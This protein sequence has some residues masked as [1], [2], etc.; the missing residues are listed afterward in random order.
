[1]DH[2]KSEAGAFIRRLGGEEWLENPGHHLRGYARTRVAHGQADAM[3]GLN[4]GV[5]FHQV[6]VGDDRLDIDGEDTLAAPAHGRH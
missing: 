2:R 4:L 3:R 1:M 6:A 5:A